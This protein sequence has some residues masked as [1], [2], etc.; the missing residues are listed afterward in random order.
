M[1]NAAMAKQTKGHR[2]ALSRKSP[3]SVGSLVGLD[4]LVGSNLSHMGSHNRLY[5]KQKWWGCNRKDPKSLIQLIN[6]VYDLR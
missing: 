3:P 2:L 6:F 4:W 1:V 5:S